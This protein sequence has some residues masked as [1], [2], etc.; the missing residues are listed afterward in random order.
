[1]K[2]KVASVLGL[3]FGEGSLHEGGQ[4]EYDGG[5]EVE[6]RLWHLR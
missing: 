4:T 1:M 2:G 6:M 5:F 3:E